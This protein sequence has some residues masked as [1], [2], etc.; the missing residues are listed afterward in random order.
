MQ[1]GFGAACTAFRLLSVSR[2]SH[3]N[4]GIGARE[5]IVLFAK[6][7]ALCCLVLVALFV[8][9]A[10]VVPTQAALGDFSLEDEAELGQKFNILV[11]S[12]F[13][14]IH[15]PIVVNQVQDIL[16][17]VTQTL[18]SQ[19]FDT[20]LGILRDGSVNAFAAPAGY[21]FVNSGL[22]LAMRSEDELAA[23]LA[24]EM[25]HVTER[26]IARNIERSQAINLA[27]LAGVLAGVMLG[28][29]SEAGQALA[30]GSMASG[31]AAALKYSRDDERE[32]DH[33]GLQYLARSGYDPEGMARAFERIKERMRLSGTGGRPA[34]MSTHPGVTER[35]G[36]I[37]DVAQRLKGDRSWDSGPSRRF[38]KVQTL[39]R[40]R[41]TDA[42]SAWNYFRQYEGKSC[43]RRLGSGIAAARLNRIDRAREL[44]QGEPPCEH[45]SALWHR[46]LGRFHFGLGQFDKARFHLEKALDESPNDYMALFFLARIM[47]EKGEIDQAEEALQRVIRYVPA[48][49]QVHRTLG[50]I[51]GR[52]GDTFS[53]YLHYAYAAL[54]RNRKE[55]CASYLDKLRQLAESGEQRQKL[56]RFEEKYEVRKK[57]W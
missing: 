55:K 11:R 2:C 40:A 10:P 4:A 14:L 9:V 30:V 17:R 44:L 12:R 31:Q 54:Y 20:T 3:A 39:L 27:T 16:T 37:R 35:I 15:D 36:Y 53:G 50:R 57:Y 21:V 45:I 18:P 42:E 46:E 41:Y 22:V 5:E 1:A 7:K 43:F 8:V 52:S 48:D 33:L 28:G 13:P 26:H 34:Y 49:A 56:E 6:G 51:L 29:G 38:L 19:P 47:G 25:A 23:V 24:H 32:A